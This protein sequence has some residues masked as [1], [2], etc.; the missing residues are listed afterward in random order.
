MTDSPFDEEVFVG[1]LRNRNNNLLEGVDAKF[2]EIPVPW[3]GHKVPLPVVLPNLHRHR[4]RKKVVGSS[5]DRCKDKD[6]SNK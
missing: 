5:Y 2:E 4:K 1:G 3:N 6:L